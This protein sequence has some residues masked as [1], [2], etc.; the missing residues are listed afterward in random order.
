MNKKNDNETIIG[1]RPV[2]E[3][4]NAGKNFVKILVKR[5]LKGEVCQECL[6]LAIEN[7][8]PVQY[9]PLEKLN[10]I[11]RS[12]HQGVIA[13]ISP[14]PYQDITTLLPGIYELGKDP[15]LLIL[16]GITD[17]RNF[18][19]IARSAE[20]AGVD[21]ILVGSKK[22]AMINSDAIKTSAGALNR[23]PVCREDDLGKTINFLQESGIMIV[24]ASEKANDLYFNADFT[25]PIAIIMGAEDTGISGTALKRIDKLLKIPMVGK[26]SSLNVG[27][28]CGVLLFE[29]LKQRIVSS[30]NQK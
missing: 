19:A 20:A 8:I 25:G 3:A 2:I 29:G 5:G 21:A 18:G 1:L 11:S 6:G 9:V 24:G 16:D 10:S 23:I 26:I 4:I 30:I 27:V 22:A 15:F 12:N 28:A 17:I 14:I 13:I 7:N